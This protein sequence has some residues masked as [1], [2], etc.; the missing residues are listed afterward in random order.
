MGWWMTWEEVCSMICGM[1]MHTRDSIRV[2]DPEVQQQ[3]EALERQVRELKASR[4]ALREELTVR[5]Q[6]EEERRRFEQQ[7]QHAQKLE[8]LGVLAGGIAHDFN[9]QLMGVL[10]NLEM[11]LDEL[12]EGATSRE[13]LEDADLSAQH[14]A[15]LTHQM[16]AYSGKGTYIVRP[17]DVSQLVLGMRELILSSLGKGVVLNLD[18][19]NDLPEIDGDADQL[20]QV[21]LNFV[22]NAS[23]AIGANE[24]R[25]T[26]AARVTDVGEEELR[27]VYPAAELHPG[28]FV[29]LSVSDTGDG[30]SDDILERIFDPFFSTKF[31]GRGLGLAVTLGIVRA[32]RGALIVDSSPREG[33]TFQALFPLS[34]RAVDK[35]VAEVPKPESP[36]WKGSGLI[37]AVD[38]EATVLRVV[39]RMLEKS[40][41]DT[42]VAVDG[43]AAVE[44]FEQYSDEI[45]AVI[46]DLTMPKMDGEAAFGKMAEI[47]PEIPIFLASGYRE[48]MLKNR[49]SN[50]T[51]PAG[52]IQKPYHRPTLVK[53]LRSVLES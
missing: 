43:L 14:M 29:V 17:V 6:A 10:G 41:F 49:F 46:L 8:S 31:T 7:I 40:G 11:A 22:T 21:V 39:Q 27:K 18:L 50:T 3:I 42:L 23:E 45:V 48:E 53:K 26:L 15:K 19:A 12:P 47:N 4:E 9:N 52:F 24:G 25:I 35:P 2:D 28:R 30:M 5:V 36:K 44:I 33:T 16:L 32:H 37:L 1:P 38:D 13:Y 34:D 51:R 20:R